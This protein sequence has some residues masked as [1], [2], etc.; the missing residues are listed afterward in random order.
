MRW[1]EYREL[2]DIGGEFRTSIGD[3]WSIVSGNSFDL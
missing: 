3:Y 1:F 2:W